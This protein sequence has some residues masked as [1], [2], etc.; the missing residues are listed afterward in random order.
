VERGP[1]RDHDPPDDVSHD[2]SDRLDLQ[3]KTLA[4]SDLDAQRR[5]AFRAQIAAIRAEQLVCVD[6][7]A[8]TI[9]L[10]RR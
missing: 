5:A 8:T 3:K 2:S 9:A 4:A 10:T 1:R 6:E 7:T